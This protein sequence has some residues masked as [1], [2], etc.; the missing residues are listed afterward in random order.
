LASFDDG[1]AKVENAA[2]KELMLNTV[3]N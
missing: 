1:Q 3:S 2:G